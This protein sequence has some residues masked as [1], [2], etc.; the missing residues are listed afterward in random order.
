MD[1]KNFIGHCHLT[2]KNPIAAKNYPMI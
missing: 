2:E 1:L